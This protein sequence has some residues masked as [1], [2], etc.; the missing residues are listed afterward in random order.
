MRTA[1]TDL[2]V[3]AEREE[4]RVIK[5]AVVGVCGR[6]GMSIASLAGA[7]ED[8]EL[9][10]ATEV[11]GH[12]SIGRD[13]GDFIEG[14]GPGVSVS[15]SIEVAARAADVIIDFTVPEV[16]LA[17]AEYSVRNEKLM[18]IGTTG[19]TSEQ[20]EKLLRLLDRIPCVF[21]PNMSVGVNVLFE[22]SRQ[23]ASHLGESYDAEIF[24]THHRGKADSPS[25]TAIALAEAVAAGLGSELKDVARYERHGRIG[26]RKK[27]GNR[28]S[29]ASGRR[30][31]RRSHSHVPWRRRKSGAYPQ[32]DQQGE[33]FLGCASRGEM[34]SGKTPGSL[35][36]AGRAWILIPQR[37]SICTGSELSKKKRGGSARLGEIRTSRETVATP[38]FMPVAT[39]GAGKAISP[40]DLRRLG[41]SD[42][43]RKRLPSLLKARHGHS[44]FPRRTSRIHV[45]GRCDCY[46]QWRFSGS[47][48]CEKQKDHG[49]WSLFPLPHRRKRTFFLAPD[50]NSRSGKPWFRRDDVF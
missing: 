24:E 30:R 42:S 17:H 49:R 23:V 41:F 26:A 9:V 38:A 8:I 40:L 35:R 3:K 11:P 27:R 13:L 34:D 14:A 12:V 2:R 20:R 16:T 21:S 47:K 10:G 7:D 31:G 15:D 18:V 32:G 4:V 1:V 5:V 6:M 48:P 25:G 43:H 19:F 28:Y 50:L 29:D 37:L 45:V 44:K 36:D 39:Q 22:I 33:F 46:R